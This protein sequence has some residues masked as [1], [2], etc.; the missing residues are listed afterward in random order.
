MKKSFLA[1]AIIVALVAYY[2]GKSSNAT[3]VAPIASPVGTTQ[4][5]FEMKAKCATYR[6][7]AEAKMKKTMWS[8]YNIDDLFYSPVLNS[9][10]YA[11]TALQNNRP[12]PYGAY[13]IWDYLTEDMLFY[14]DTSLSKGQDIQSIYTNAKGYLMGTESMK[15]SHDDWG[16]DISELPKG[17]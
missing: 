10:L 12:T 14:R 8:S 13:I 9:C 7:G 11:V 3:K 15:F 6:E 2:F 17:K 5:A 4:E 16:T 1:I